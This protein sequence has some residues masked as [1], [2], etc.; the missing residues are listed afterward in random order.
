MQDQQYSQFATAWVVA[1]KCGES[2]KVS[3]DVAGQVMGRMRDYLRSHPYDQARLN[4]AISNISYKEP[5]QAECNQMAMSLAAN[6]APVSVPTPP[7]PLP[8]RPVQTFCNQ[9]GTQTLCT[10]M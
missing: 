2:G 5:S 1:N 9:I 6:P 7:T 4:Q 3:A 8:N 10:S